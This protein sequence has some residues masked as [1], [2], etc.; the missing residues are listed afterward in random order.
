MCGWLAGWLAVFAN[1]CYAGCKSNPITEAQSF[2]V[3]SKCQSY[4]CQLK[5]DKR[6]DVTIPLSR[7]FQMPFSAGRPVQPEDEKNLLYVAVTRAK[8]CLQISPT[9]HR[10]LRLCGETFR[11]PVDTEQLRAGGVTMRCAETKVVFDPLPCT[12]TRREVKLVSGGSPYSQPCPLIRS[13]R[14]YSMARYHKC[15][16]L[17]HTGHQELS[18]MYSI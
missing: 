13:H 15:C 10:L 7:I 4:S 9:V 11:Y 17:A 3:T 16:V 1:K 6:R 2:P 8:R 14:C 12:I 5:P 18:Q